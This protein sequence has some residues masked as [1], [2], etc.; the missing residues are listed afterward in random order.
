MINIPVSAGELIDKLTILQI[1]R[2]KVKDVDKLKNVTK[3]LK[4]LLIIAK[5]F[6]SDAIVN[7]LYEEL[8]A[9]NIE[10]W[11]IEDRLRKL[12]KKKTFTDEF[13]QLARKVYISND[14]RFEIK[15]SIN[16]ILD[17]EIV[18]VKQY[19]KY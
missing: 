8:L 19:I 6:M 5:T 4:E 2:G 11:E 17:S 9:T 1:K 7:I 16:K 14:R 13:I 15:N 3:E 12:E 10:L 18:E